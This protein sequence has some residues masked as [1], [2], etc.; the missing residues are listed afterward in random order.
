MPLRIIAELLIYLFSLSWYIVVIFWSINQTSPGSLWLSLLWLSTDSLYYS[1][2]GCLFCP[3]GFLSS[4]FI[5]YMTL[6]A[7]WISDVEKY[8][9]GDYFFLHDVA[10]VVYQ[11]IRWLCLF[12]AHAHHPFLILPQFMPPCILGGKFLFLICSLFF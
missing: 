2:L 6:R 12:S 8:I 7:Y 1:S 11:S 4:L 9:W 5:H 3:S 10:L